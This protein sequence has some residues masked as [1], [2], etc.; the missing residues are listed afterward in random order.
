MATQKQLSLQLASVER[1][2]L[3]SLLQQLRKHFPEQVQQVILFG[4]KARND[5]G[6]DSDTDLLVL[7]KDET[8]AL[9]HAIWKLASRVELEHGDLLFNIQVI[10]VAR[11]QVMTRAGFSLC[12]SVACEGIAL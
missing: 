8:W 2:G 9:R 4:S 1:Q 7:V 3:E 12:Q 10:S 11:W 6:P 5:S